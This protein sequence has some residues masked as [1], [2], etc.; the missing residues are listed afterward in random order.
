LFLAERK[1]GGDRVAVRVLDGG[2]NGAENGPDDS[3]LESLREHV[4]RVSA[5]NARCPAIASLHEC[6]RAEGGGLYLALEH[7]EAPTLA[8]VLQR[9]GQLEPE[10]AVRLAV[11]VA[12]TLE[13]AHM[14]GIPHGGL[15]PRNIV[16]VGEDETVK[17]TEFGVDW[18][19]ARAGGVERHRASGS[20]YLAPEQR[21]SGEATPQGDVYAVGAVLYEALA[22]RPPEA[23]TLS[24][25]RVSIQPLRKMRP[26]VSRALEHIVTRALESDPERRYRDMTDLFNDL[27]SEI[28]PF[29]GSPPAGLDA[30][31]RRRPDGKRTRLIAVGIV[32]GAIGVIALLSRLLVAGPPALVSP[33]PPPAPLPQVA[34]PALA[35]PAPPPAAVDSE[36][37][38]V[39]PPAIAAPQ[40]DAVAPP[41]AP[42]PVVEPPARPTP[43]PVR[44]T[45]QA[46]PA[47]PRPVVEPP[48]ARAT[49]EAPP[50]PPR[51]VVEP[52]ARPTPPPARATGQAP[53]APPRPVVEPPARPTPPPVRAT[54]EAPRPPARPA[55]S[56]GPQEKPIRP[57]PRPVETSPSPSAPRA[58]QAP[59]APAP[60]AAQVPAPSAPAA[61]PARETSED[62]GA[63]IDWLLKES[64]S[65]RR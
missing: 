26:D 5:L 58:A 55:P 10:R 22:G 49:V 8:E 16:L 62:G 65:A 6:G 32:F 17:L 29:S 34:A 63:I 53:P 1:A 51:P 57:E 36:P 19:R 43:P 28:S 31:P 2:E 30:V 45:A 60:R 61:A 23:Q 21:A 9:E 24:R 50:A 35:P 39:A 18:L 40:P 42:R 47:P 11:R 7:P 12:E 20:P 54:V 15:A 44:A 33:P 59:S 52:P 37:E 38:P 25:R 56:V 46:P 64:S 4:V 3:L 13:S 48:P 14:L 41:A 27:W